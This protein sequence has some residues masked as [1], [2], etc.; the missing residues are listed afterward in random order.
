MLDTYI[1]S[2]EPKP[3]IGR[4][5]LE[6]VGLSP[7]SGLAPVILLDL[8]AQIVPVEAKGGD[9]LEKTDHLLL[10]FGLHHFEENGLRA[11][12]ESLHGIAD[13]RRD[14]RGVLGTLRFDPCG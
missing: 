14:P 2:G 8:A 4:I 13:S 3:L 10:A 6:D 7:G 11:H 12:P 9:S 5:E 1:C